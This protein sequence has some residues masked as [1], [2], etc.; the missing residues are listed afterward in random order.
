MTVRVER[1]PVEVVRPL[2]HAVLRAG[3]PLTHA[4]NPGDDDPDVT[5]LAVLDGDR[6]LACASLYREPLHGRE[7]WRLRGMASDPSVRGRGYGAMALAA[8]LDVVMRSELPMVWCNA[9]TSALPFYEKYGFVAQ[10]EEFITEQGIP[11][12]LATWTAAVAS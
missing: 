7:S 8:A 6:V 3:Q 10:G 2:R 11:H 4:D 5:H 12:Y 9:R 1:V